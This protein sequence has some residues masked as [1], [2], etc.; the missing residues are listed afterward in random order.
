M[1]QAIEHLPSKHEALSSIPG[2]TKKKKKKNEIVLFLMIFVQC[3]LIKESKKQVRI[4]N[5]VV[6]RK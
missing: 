4:Y 1:A 6:V 3:I 2:S 5:K